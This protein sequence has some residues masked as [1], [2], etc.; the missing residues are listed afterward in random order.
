M[1]VNGGANGTGTIFKL[2]TDGTDY[3]LIRT[4]EAAG[5]E[6][7]PT[8]PSP[9]LIGSLKEFDKKQRLDEARK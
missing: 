1:T 7:D 4:S 6:L 5:S 3:G 9:E 2:N 8:N